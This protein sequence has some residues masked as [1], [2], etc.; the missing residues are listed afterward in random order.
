MGSRTQGN[1]GGSGKEGTRKVDIVR[2]SKRDK[3]AHQFNVPFANIKDLEFYLSMDKMFCLECGLEFRSLG[4]HLARTHSMSS[5]DYKKKYNI[6][7]IRSLACPDFQKIRGE[8]SKSNWEGGGMEHVRERI[9]EAGKN[10]GTIGNSVKRTSNI[11]EKEYKK[12]CPQCKQTFINKRN[13]YTYCSLKCYH[14]SVE[15]SDISRKNGALG[16][17]RV[18]AKR[19]K[20]GKFS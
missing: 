15:C 9:K 5:F 13:K 2:A 4:H 12:I 14:S 3:A 7:K 16:G 1:Y 8:L 18:D 11:H 17:R 6:P 20:K 19:D 10:F